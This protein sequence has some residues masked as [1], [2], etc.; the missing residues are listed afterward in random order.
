MERVLCNKANWLVNNAGYEVSIVTTDQKGR[1]PFFDFSPKIRM[2]DLQVNYTDLQGKNFVAKTIGFLRKQ[3]LHR[4]KLQSLLDEIR[5]DVVVSMFGHE[6]SFLY[7][8]R[9]GSKKVLEI[10]FSK[11][12]RL[13]QQRGGVWWLADKWRT[14]KD[15]KYIRQY[16]KFVVLTHEDKAYWGNLPNI[17]VIYNAATFTP[18][19][20]ARLENKRVLSVGRLTFQKGYDMLLEAWA[21]VYALH[22]NWKLTIVGG[23]EEH[24]ALQQQ[25]SRLGLTDTVELKAPTSQIQ[26]EYLSS[27]I[28]VLSS[29]FEGFGLVLVEAMR[30]GLPAVAFACK[31]GPRDIISHQQDGLLVTEND[32]IGLANAICQL[33]EH[34]L[35][36][37][38]M[39]QAAMCKICENFNEQNI[40]EQ[41]RQLFMRLTTNTNNL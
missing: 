18:S 10:H 11:Y 9:D 12:F 8:M 30:C 33:I 37:K 17:E 2:C 1:N 38:Q 22:P 20:T 26:E 3:K 32:I 28:Y 35:L 19:E 24:D 25:I 21:K 5:A 13:Q 7:R 6:V 23:G 34:P 4:Q 40:M 36:R 29:R 27:S 16:N 41:W 39:G 31:C 15:Q 14:W